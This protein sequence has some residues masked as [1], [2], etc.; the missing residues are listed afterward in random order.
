MS[1][2]WMFSRC[3]AFVASGNLIVTAPS[4]SVADAVLSGK[5]VGLVGVVS[6][7]ETFNISSTLVDKISKVRLGQIQWNG[8]S[9]TAAASLYTSLQHKCNGTLLQTQSSAVIIDTTAGTITV[10][11]LAIDAV[12]MYIV[13]VELRSTNNQYVIPLTS[14]GILVKKPTS[15]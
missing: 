1:F 2:N 13:K 11:N 10:T 7:N 5:Q 4:V 9:W 15:E 6:I 3:S 12:G 8:F 14:T